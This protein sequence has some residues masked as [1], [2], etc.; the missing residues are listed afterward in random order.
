MADPCQTE[1]E[2]D[3]S[4]PCEACPAGYTCQRGTGL[5]VAKPGYCMES[6]RADCFYACVDAYECPGYANAT[7]CDGRRH[8]EDCAEL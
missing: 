3:G 1:D 2:R 8:L 7:V 4:E 6:G 5:P